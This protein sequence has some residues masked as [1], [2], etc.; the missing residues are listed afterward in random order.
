LFVT[1]G[2]ANNGRGENTNLKIILNFHS[3]KIFANL[4]E[5]LKNFND[6]LKNHTDRTQSQTS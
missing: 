4:H 2:G 5:F 3:L 1:G 6:L